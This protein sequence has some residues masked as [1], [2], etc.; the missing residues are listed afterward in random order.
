[1]LAGQPSRG[2]AATATGDTRTLC[3]PVTFITE[4]C[5]RRLVARGQ[6]RV[7]HVRLRLKCDT[8]PAPAGARRPSCS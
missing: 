8:E 1:V 2:R 7:R 6:G 5:P 3:A 4:V